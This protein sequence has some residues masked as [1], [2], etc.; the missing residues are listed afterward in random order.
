LRIEE[1]S[2]K[3]KKIQQIKSEQQQQQ[4]PILYSETPVK[5]GNYYT[6]LNFYNPIGPKE[7]F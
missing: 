3:V 7:I 1:E 4:Q 5:N 2:E 6:T